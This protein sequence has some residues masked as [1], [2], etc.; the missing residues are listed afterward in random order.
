MVQVG[1]DYKHYSNT[2]RKHSSFFLNIHIITY[3]K[4]YYRNNN[5]NEMYFLV[6]KLFTLVNLTLHRVSL[7]TRILVLI[8][9]TL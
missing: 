8:D 2:Y 5:N 3:D 7:R 4:Y 6:L 9:E 1:K